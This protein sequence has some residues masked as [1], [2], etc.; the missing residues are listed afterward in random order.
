MQ[1]LFIVLGGARSGKSVFAEDLALR[2]ALARK[3]RKIYLATARAEWDGEPDPAFQKRIAEHRARRGA[4][5]E[6][7]EAP[8]DLE[9]ALL[10]ADGADRL[11]LVDCLTLWLTNRLLEAENPEKADLE[12]PIAALV[13]TLERLRA[14]TIVVS[15]EVGLGVVPETT[16]GRVF[17]DAQ[18]RLNRLVAAQAGTAVFVAAGL[19]LT[20][21]G[22]LTEWTEFKGRAL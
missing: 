12:T 17:R 4:D 5:W 7:I 21:K 11:L 3:L 9:A 20:L 8:D 1:R 2:T 14:R 19:P 6:T 10:R 18:G 15:N 22:D 13:A 16:L